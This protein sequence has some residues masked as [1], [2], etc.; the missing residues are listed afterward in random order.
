MAAFLV[1]FFSF[2]LYL[3]TLAPTF[4]WSDSAKLAIAV[5]EK[6]FAATS[7]GA[8]PM[9]TLLGYL[10]SALPFSFAYTQNLISAVFASA[11]VVLIYA[12]VRMETRDT[13]SAILA[14]AGL[15]VSH[16]FWMYGVINETYSL[17]AFFLAASLYCSLKYLK[18]NSIRYLYRLTFLIGAGFANHA[19]MVL[20]LPGILV[21]L[22]KRRRPI[23]LQ[24][25]HWLILLACFVLGA[26]PVLILPLL[27]GQTPLTILASL[28]KTTE[29]HYQTFSSGISKLLRQVGYYPL[30]LL[31]QFPGVSLIAAVYGIRALQRQNQRLFFGS[32]IIWVTTVLFASQYFMQRQFPMLIPSFLIIAIWSGY[33]F[34]EWRERYPLA[35]NKS[36]TLVLL[37][38][39]VLIPPLIYYSSY[40]I[41]EKTN[42]DLSFI[43]KLPYRNNARYFLYPPKHLERGAEQYVQDSFRQAEEG[44]ILLSDFNPGMALLYGQKILRKRKDL[45][46]EI[47]IDD[48]IHHSNDP[49]AELLKYV[50]EKNGQNR[51]VYL[52]DRYEPYYHSSILAPEFDLIQS[53]GPL[54]KIRKRGE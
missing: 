42:P 34:A 40:R 17:V 5:H 26:G 10:F 44:A 2:L 28:G 54:W 43:R 38:S 7:F 3:A 32:L 16:I 15:A 31:Y 33:G 6:Q 9:H 37:I 41:I 19:M 20:F 21:L 49:A 30:Y 51:T 24:T 36:V 4:L 35:R 50:R 13:V 14:A 25:R 23:P 45:Q 22:I 53:G 48:W 11:T 29:Q 46:I 1:F 27:Q 39:V 47:L 52:A 12:I 18:E 8:H